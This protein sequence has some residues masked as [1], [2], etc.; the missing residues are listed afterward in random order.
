MRAV[1]LTV[2]GV[3]LVDLEDE[4][5]LGPT[6]GADFDPPPAAQPFKL[7]VGM[8]AVFTEERNGR[9]PRANTVSVL[10]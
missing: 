5:V 6:P 1:V 4:S 7:A 10:A 8:A 3:C 9:E 2:D